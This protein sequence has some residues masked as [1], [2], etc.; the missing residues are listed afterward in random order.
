MTDRTVNYGIKMTADG[1]GLVGATTDA[2]KAQEKLEE[3]FKKTTASTKSTAEES[4]RFVD[5]LKEQAD[6]LGKSRAEMERYRASQLQL[7]EAQKKSVEE[8][9]RSIEIH[10]KKTEVL[11]KVRVAAVAA[12]AAIVALGSA[13]V[14]AA[15][16]SEKADNRLLAVLR[17]T[18]H[19][20]GIT[21]GELDSMADA[22]QRSTGFDDEGIKRGQAE[23]LKFGNIHGN[24]FRDAIRISADLA[25]FMGTDVSSAAQ[26]VGRSLQS[27]TE[28]LMMM[29]RQ[30]GRLTEAEEAHIEKLV[31]QGRAVEAQT[32][33]LELW[34]QK[35]EGTGEIM[36][37]GLTKATSDLGNAWDDMLEAL[38]KTE[39]VGGTVVKV[40]DEITGALRGMQSLAKQDPLAP[41]RDNLTLVEIEIKRIEARHFAGGRPSPHLDARLAE[42]RAERD[43]LRGIVSAASSTAVDPFGFNPA[44]LDVRLGGRKPPPPAAGGAVNVA[45]QA[46]A[47]RR[48]MADAI[49]ISHKNAEA[50]IESGKQIEEITAK[51]SQTFSDAINAP[52]V[53]AAELAV[54]AGDQLVYTYD[55]FG[56]QLVL[57]KEQFEALGKA[58]DKAGEEMSASAKQAQR[59][60]ERTADNIERALTSSIMKGG[61]SGL[62]HL[63]DA[64]RTAIL[65]PIIQPIVR[66]VANMMAGAVQG[67][68]SSIFG[69]GGGGFGSSFGGSAAG[70]FV[71]PGMF[72]G[73]QLFADF[74]NFF[75]NIGATTE[76]GG[77]FGL[78]DAIGGFAMA[79]PLATAGIIGGGFLLGDALGLFGDGGSAIPQVELGMRH[80]A[81]DQSLYANDP[82]Y[83]YAVD[84]LAR[85]HRQTFGVGWTQFNAN[86][87]GTNPDV[88]RQQIMSI[89]QPRADQ[90]R[91]RSTAASVL[92]GFRA[93][94][95]PA[96]FWAARA[97]SLSQQVTGG[98]VTTFAGWKQALEQQVNAGHVGDQESLRIWLEFGDAL[99]KAAESAKKAGEEEGQLALQ[100]E[101][102]T[103][104]SRSIEDAL[105]RLAREI[106]GQLGIVA[107][108]DA[109]TANA[110]SEY[111]APLDRLSNANSLLRSTYDQ[112]LGGDISAVGMFPQ[113][114]QQALGIGR[115][116]YASGPQFQSMFV[117]GNRMLQDLL[118]HQRDVQDS[119]LSD[120]VFATQEA[121]ND[122]VAGLRQM[123]EAIVAKLDSVES[124]LRRIAF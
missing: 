69:G 103:S 31:E 8:S 15:I 17:A 88:L 113:V 111:M 36:H 100:R 85:Q 79:N 35:V 52:L 124:E 43:S 44:S 48:A 12:A 27:P 115:D 47:A 94:E 50:W 25:A 102:L 13:S 53:E 71:S 55:Q 38:G 96:G 42:L 54:E 80:P 97:A 114:L 9:T 74:G 37:S 106:P 4:K 82:D 120:I 72:G 58:S 101:R 122:T 83:R 116:V 104:E 107:L 7:T 77:T 112:A 86:G 66:P 45:A 34:R 109:I 10:D 21:K 11:K 89:Y 75:G 73:G 87:D 29:E 57:T 23:L 1:Q 22:M 90:R 81:I 119:L 105:G 26:M 24:V 28:G 39:V 59:D 67:I 61:K 93:D 76:M 84:E 65:T 6:T 117:E 60:W 95:D 51:G 118:N 32:A 110:V 68:G 108:Q 99:K 30:F 18:G 41:F 56:N 2:T 20:A 91:V 62:E 46:E 123:K 40:L 5:R 19:A 121:K 98:T 16:E 14:Q 78:M 63:Q 49:M 3:Q 64:L 70:N 33:V 92:D